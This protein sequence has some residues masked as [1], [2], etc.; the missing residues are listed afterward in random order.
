MNNTGQMQTSFAEVNG[1]RLYYEVAGEGHPLALSHSF[2]SNKSLWDDQ[3]SAFAQH[4][5]VI[6][7]DLRGFGSS[8]L[9]QGPYSQREDLYALL[10]FLG[11]EKTFLLGIS[12]SSVIARPAGSVPAAKSGRCGSRETG[13]QADKQ[14]RRRNLPRRPCR[15]CCAGRRTSCSWFTMVRA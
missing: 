1:T 13:R 6:R 4:Y 10:K 5:K 15:A 3:F 14:T 2:I 8:G 12:G 7:Y 11:I 9:I